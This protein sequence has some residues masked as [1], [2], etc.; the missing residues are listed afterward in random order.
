MQQVI[1]KIVDHRDQLL[2][3]VSGRVEA[4]RCCLDAQ[5]KSLESLKSQLRDSI[6]TI[7]SPAL[8]NSQVESSVS[9]NDDSISSSFNW[10]RPYRFL[11]SSFS[12]GK[13]A[14]VSDEQLPL[15]LAD[16]V[17][18][19]AYLQVRLMN[20]DEISSAVEDLAAFREVSIL[21]F[22]LPCQDVC[23]IS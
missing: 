1:K 21:I 19:D 22:S 3:E 2:A 15:P 23:F 10:L 16:F 9:A 4:R 18:Q 6:S 11:S 8:A 5:T 20:S 17:S 14:N 12:G 7:S 13:S